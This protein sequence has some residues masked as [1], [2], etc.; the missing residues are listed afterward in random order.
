MVLKE[1]VIGEV[2]LFVSDTV[3]I[4]VLFQSVLCLK[5]KLT[6]LP[7]S[8]VSIY[9]WSVFPLKYFLCL[10]LCLVATLKTVC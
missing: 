6:D 5:G 7:N 8:D 3:L 9:V 4:P 10:D 1:Q 2:S